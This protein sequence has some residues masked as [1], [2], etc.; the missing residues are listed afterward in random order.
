MNH[1][2]LVDYHKKKLFFLML[3]SICGFFL[4]YWM[5]TNADYLTNKN[6]DGYSRYNFVGN[7]LHEKPLLLKIFAFFLCLLFCYGFI[8]STLKLIMQKA[9]FQKIDGN[10][11]INGKSIVQLK[12]IQ[13]ISELNYNKNENYVR[14]FL[15][16]PENYIKAAKNPLKKFIL[17][18]N[19]KRFGTPLLIQT[20]FYAESSEKII[21][22][23]LKLKKH[24]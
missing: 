3:F 4:F 5:F 16:N 24:R 21:A 1:E 10:L 12:E 9:S 13:K 20:I 18:S 22:K 8:F 17:K 2:F 14:I 15:I 6:P 19:Y 11:H 23:I 7:L